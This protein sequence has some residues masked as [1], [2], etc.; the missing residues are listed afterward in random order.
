[1]TDGWHPQVAFAAGIQNTIAWY[2][3]HADLDALQKDFD[4]RLFERKV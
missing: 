3:A 4:K 1:L 2:Q